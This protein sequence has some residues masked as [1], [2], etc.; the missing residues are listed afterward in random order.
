MSTVFPMHRAVMPSRTR[1]RALR[2]GHV[3]ELGLRGVD[4]LVVVGGA[5]V[6]SFFTFVAAIS[7]DDALLVL[8][9]F[10]VAFIALSAARLYEVRRFADVGYQT[11]RAVAAWLA[12]LAVVVTVM[13][14]LRPDEL[15][16]R[17]WVLAWAAVSTCGLVGV[18]FA[19]RGLVD[20]LR[21]QGQFRWNVVVVGSGLW[22]HEA[23]RRL[24]ADR[25]EATVASFFDLDDFTDL[26]MLEGAL[27]Q[28]LAA[29]CVDQIAVALEPQDL[30]RLPDLLAV[31]RTF[32]LEVG[33]L[34]QLGT[35]ELPTLG[36]RRV[37]EV[38]TVTCLRKPI[39]G[40]AWHVKSAF[41]RVAASILLVFFAPLMLVIAMGVRVSSPGPILFRQS[42]LGFNQQPIDVFKF[43][44]MYADRCDAPAA[45]QV[46]QAI[47]DDPRVTPLGSVLRRTSLDEL[48][49]LFNVLRGEMSLVGPRPHAIAHDEYYAALIDGY[50]GRQRAKPGITGWAQV[51]GCRGEIHSL[52]DMRRRIE[53][54]LYY[55][56]NWSLW[57]D[58][59]ILVRTMLVF[60]R[61]E[62]AY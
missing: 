55:I 28:Q 20:T 44:S 40:W 46:K 61:D 29:K 13:F 19:L 41:D 3:L 42:R 39:D 16:A 18:R 17:S 10:L 30:H 45:D 38:T 15:P 48:P 31:L 50:L 51:S 34:P 27:R 26:G 23:R 12:T 56:D 8:L 57:F 52:E 24:E 37:G 25:L 43:R 35:G 60:L 21:A 4:L 2:P 7:T 11:G 58:L 32:P 47:R 54:D 22:G 5:Y 1:P 6:A 49:Q 62:R 59:K 9:T 33:L 53:L 14:L 36:Y